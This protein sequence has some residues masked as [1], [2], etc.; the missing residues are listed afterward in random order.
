M[1]QDDADASS[2]ERRLLLRARRLDDLSRRLWAGVTPG[3]R[4]VAPPVRPFGEQPTAPELKSIQ[5][6]NKAVLAKLSA[7]KLSVRVAAKQGDQSKI[8]VRVRKQPRSAG[9]AG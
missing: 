6:S 7:Q 3:G 1:V 2:V 5:H 8:S 4:P 9:E